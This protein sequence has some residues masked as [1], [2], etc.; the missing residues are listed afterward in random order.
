MVYPTSRPGYTNKRSP[1][2]EITR[3]VLLS[4]EIDALSEN[5]EVLLYG[6]VCFPRSCVD[7]LRY[8]RFSLTWHERLRVSNLHSR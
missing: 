2:G 6:V 5:E 8:D 7:H 1:R 4:C 3:F